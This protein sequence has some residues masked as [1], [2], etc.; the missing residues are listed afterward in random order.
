MI[1]FS[2]RDQII[3]YIKRHVFFNEGYHTANV[4]ESVERATLRYM[5]EMQMQGES[6]EQLP[7]FAGRIFADVTTELRW[8]MTVSTGK[9]LLESLGE[10]LRESVRLSE[11][12]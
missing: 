9:W 3:D 1:T 6:F 11:S 8:R 12:C 10:T 5:N 2:A 7:R 4:I